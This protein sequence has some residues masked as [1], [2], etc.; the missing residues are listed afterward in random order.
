M[1]NYFVSLPPA[2]LQGMIWGIMAIGVYLTYR[3]LDVADLTVDGSICTG[4]AVC[5][6]LVV[7]FNCP[8]WLALLAAMAAGMLAGLCTGLFH[9]VLG[10]PAIL[11][12]IL[13]QLMLWSV[14]IKIMG[15]TSNVGYPF[16]FRSF[17]S[18]DKAGALELVNKVTGW[19]SISLSGTVKNYLA[20]V[21]KVIPAMFFVGLI[22][23][24]VIA[25]LYW[26]F[27]TEF[28]ACIRATGCN[29]E[30]SRAQGINT[31]RNKVIGLV[32]SNGIVAFAGGVLSLFLGFSDANAGRG[33]IV[34]G[35]AAVII[36]EALF[37][38]LAKDNFAIKLSSVV[39]G[40]MIY[41]IVYQ[42][43]ISLK[44][45]TNYLK[46]FS[47]LLVGLALGVPYLKNKY[48]GKFKKKE[49][50]SVQKNAEGGND[51]A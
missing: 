19:L 29:L 23:A 43:I 36:G 20:D 33:A 14:N 17:L 1:I 27:G 50:T 46:L 2:V 45:D 44:I 6:V 31:D 22:I 7:K 30:M 9:T 35:L 37:S 4:M 49:K 5:A 10:I 47:A 24:V 21:L 40:G 51:N 12:G 28:G 25:V 39:V 8:L 11:S 34:I 18:Y 16:N 13:T 26:F 3:I 15:G 32:I 41:Y 38:K 48:A 42:T